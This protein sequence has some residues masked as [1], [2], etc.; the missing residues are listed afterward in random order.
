MKANTIEKEWSLDLDYSV[1][2]GE[3]YTGFMEG[4]KE[5]KFLGNKIGDQ[6]F[7]PPKPFCNRTYELPSGWV[8]SDGTGTVE[9]FTIYQKEPEGIVYPDAKVE[10]SPPYIVAVIRISNSDQC[11]IHLISGIDANDPEQL[12]NKV[13]A[14][15]TVRPV[16][17]EERHGNI[18]DIK[19]FEPVE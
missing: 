15:L 2:L 18:L 9:A 7:F 1:S 17:A 5:K 12:L 13:S 6:T 10:L 3:T 16:W 8:E 11:L 4:L 19:Y 14:G